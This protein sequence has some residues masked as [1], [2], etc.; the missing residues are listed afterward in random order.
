[1]K[2]VVKKVRKGQGGVDVFPAFFPS[3]FPAS[4]FSK[5]EDTVRP[6]ALPS[7]GTGMTRCGK[8]VLVPLSPSLVY[9]TRRRLACSSLFCVAM[10]YKR[11]WEMV[12]GVEKDGRIVTKN[13]QVTP[14]EILRKMLDDELSCLA[15]IPSARSWQRVARGSARVRVPKW[16]DL[17]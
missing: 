8:Q 13:V 4:H 14:E 12:E 2:K 3:S 7:T 17:M 15:T 10:L 9:S 6:S 1:M 11:R 5:R 16:A